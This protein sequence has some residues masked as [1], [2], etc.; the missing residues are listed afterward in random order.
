MKIKYWKNFSKRRNSTKQPAALSATEIDVDILEPCSTE[1]P[2]FILSIVDTAINYVQAFGHYYYVTDRIILD[3]PRMQ[4][5]CDL[6]KLASAKSDIKNGTAL[7]KRSSSN[8]HSDLRDEMVSI[9]SSCVSGEEHVF[10]M[11]FN[12]TG[13]YLLSVVNDDGGYNGICTYACSIESVKKVINWLNGEGT[14][15]PGDPFTTIQNYLATQFGDV[16]SCIRWLKW[17]PLSD[18]SSVAESASIKLGRYTVTYTSGGTTTPV[19]GLKIKDNAIISNSATVD[20]SDYIGTDF[21][22]LSPYTSVDIFLPMQGLSSLPSELVTRTLTIEYA[23]D[24]GIGDIFVKVYSSG[25][26]NV[27][28]IASFNY[29]IAVDIPIAQIGRIANQL[30]S[31]GIGFVSAMTTGNLLHMAASSLNVISAAASNGICIKGSSEGR[32]MSADTTMRIIV[33]YMNTSNPEDLLATYGRPLEECISLSTLS[34]YL[35]TTK[36]SISTHLTPAET[37]AINAALDSGIYLE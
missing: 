10:S 32:S 34:G 3:G 18:M 8:Y 28:M 12:D 5:S 2:D 26:D 17:I 1:T 22:R 19:Y 33:T 23:I 35:Q 9:L 6:D 29:N 13:Y 16:F 25:T 21:R 15:T 11:P 36:A 31:S 24:A 30:L 7:V 37:D 4:I 14:Y 27:R 20:L